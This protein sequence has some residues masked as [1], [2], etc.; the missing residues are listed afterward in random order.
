MGEK[1]FNWEFLP[2]DW[3]GDESQDTGKHEHRKCHR[4]QCTERIAG[5]DVPVTR[6][7]VLE[8]LERHD[9]RCDER[10]GDGQIDDVIVGDGPHVSVLADRPDDHQVSDERQR[11]DQDVERDE[12][13]SDQVDLGQVNIVGRLAVARRHERVVLDFVLEEIADV[14]HVAA[15]AAA[16]LLLLL[17]LV[18]L[19]LF[20]MAILECVYVINSMFDI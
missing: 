20:G 19:L 3:Y 5:H 6:R 1:H 15:Y 9:K 7:G 17:L 13:P 2:F 4:E 12:R 8:D 14:H 10:V 11:D 18:L 16:A